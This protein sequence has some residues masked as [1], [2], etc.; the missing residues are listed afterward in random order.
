MDTSPQTTLYMWPGFQLPQYPFCFSATPFAIK[1]QRIL[2]YKRLPFAI[3][4]IHFSERNQELPLV[5]Q[6]GK[7]PILEYDGQFID[8]STQIAIFLE[9]KHPE[10]SLFSDDPTESAHIHFLE[11]WA[12]EVLYRYRQY[13]EQAFQ[14]SDRIVE[15]Y[16]DGYS[17]SEKEQALKARLES[18]RITLHHQGFG[19]YSEEKFWSEFRRSLANLSHLI[20]QNGYLVGSRVS[21]ADIAVFSQI[22]RAMAGTDPWYE[23]EIKEYPHILQWL[24]NIDELTST[25]APKDA[26]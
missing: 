1:I 8:D 19:R 12:D 18:Q 15:A 11:E 26:P 16:F 13:G 7:L 22:Y 3:K 23:T 10:F 5:T 9:E 17:D 6:S 14:T 2:N 25:P 20:S 24:K 4:E 21:L